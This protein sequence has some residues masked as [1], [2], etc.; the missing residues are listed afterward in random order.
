MFKTDVFL[1]EIE[2]KK[3]REIELNYNYLEELVPYI[4]KIKYEKFV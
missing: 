2:R 4:D 1:S 3:L